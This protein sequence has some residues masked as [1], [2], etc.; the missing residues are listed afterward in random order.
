MVPSPRAPR[1]CRLG[2]ATALGREVPVATGLGARLLGLAF[3]DRVEAGPGLLVPRCS[4]V[5]TFGMRFAL[6]ICFLDERG[7]LLAVRHGIPARRVVSHRG[8]R[9][10]L[11]IPAGEGGEFSPPSP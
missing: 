5:H 9:A 8:A 6:E 7:R 2:T 11:E 4:S 1:L 3:L 10:V